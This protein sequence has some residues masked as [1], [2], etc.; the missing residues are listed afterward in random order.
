MMNLLEI[1]KSY[2]HYLVHPFKTHEAFM[3]PEREELY[4]PIK[5]SAYESLVMSWVFII[6]N[7]IF[8][9][10][11]LNI[12]VLWLINLFTD[13]AFDFTRFINFEEFSG[14]HFVVLSTV[15]DIIFYPIFGLLIVQYWEVVIKFFGNLLQV[16]GDLNEKAQNVVSVYLSSHMFK[17]VPLIGGAFQNLAGMVLMYA[18]LRKELNASPSLSVCIIL[19][20]FVLMLALA[21]LVMFVVMLLS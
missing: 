20:P 9:V 17:L 18:G 1:F 8:K 10:F 5:F 7:G 2:A 12:T 13:S 11:I 4:H 21:S 3:H 19:S 14:M 15:L 6:I 16:Q